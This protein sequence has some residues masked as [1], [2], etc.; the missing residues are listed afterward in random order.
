MRE[1]QAG[2]TQPDMI[3]F[4]GAVERHRDTVF[5]VAFSVRVTGTELKSEEGYLAHVSPLG[6]TFAAPFGELAIDAWVPG[7]TTLQMSD[8]STYVVEDDDNLNTYC[9]YY[10]EEGALTLVFNRLVD[11]AQVTGVTIGGPGGEPLEFF[12]AG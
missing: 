1:S 2:T 7:G 6:I 5:R 11:P 9:S 12:P 3:W 4:H 8:G 10:T